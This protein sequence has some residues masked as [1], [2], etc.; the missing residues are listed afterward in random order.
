[1]K[2]TILF[3]ILCLSNAFCPKAEYHNVIKRNLVENKYDI[4][5]F[6]PDVERRNLMNLVLLFGGLIPSISALAVPYILFFIPKGTTSSDG[7]IKALTKSGDEIIFD[8]WVNTHKS[9][10]REL[11]QG[12]KGDPTYLIVDDNTIRW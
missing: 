8:T 1:M 7:G 9:G 3:C 12:L 11:V 2:S 6:I 4:H 10:D 5:S